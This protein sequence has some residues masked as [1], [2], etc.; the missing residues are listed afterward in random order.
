MNSLARTTGSEGLESMPGDS[1]YAFKCANGY[2]YVHDKF[3][4]SGLTP[5]ALEIIG[6][7]RVVECPVQIEAELVAVH[8]MMFDTEKKGKVLALEVKVVRTHVHE[9]IRMEGFD[10][11]VDPD[12]QCSPK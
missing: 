3:G 9:R 5:M 12:K 2:Q 7:S 10:N 1:R 6:P 4:H 8:E 11:R